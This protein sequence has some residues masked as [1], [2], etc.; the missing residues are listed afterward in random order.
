MRFRLFPLLLL[1]LVF[2]GPVVAAQEQITLSVAARNVGDS[3]ARR[4]VDPD[5][6]Q[7]DMLIAFIVKD[8]NLGVGAMSALEPNAEVTPTLEEGTVAVLRTRPAV[9]RPRT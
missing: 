2:S 9:R 6:K 8:G 7:A 4:V 3:I 1:T 5:D